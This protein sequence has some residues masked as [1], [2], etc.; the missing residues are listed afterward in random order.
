MGGKRPTGNPSLGGRGCFTY[1]YEVKKSQDLKSEESTSGPANCQTNPC[2]SIFAA[3]DEAAAVEA[4]G[5]VPIRH[6]IKLLVDSTSA[7]KNQPQAGKAASESQ[8]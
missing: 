4:S 7:N 8:V 5:E 1:G 2:H 6:E 3:D